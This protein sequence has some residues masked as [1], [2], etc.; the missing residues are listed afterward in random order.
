VLFLGKDG[1]VV[2]EAVL[3]QESG[4]TVRSESAKA[5]FVLVSSMTYPAA[6]MSVSEVSIIR[7]PKS[8]EVK[9]HTEEGVLQAQQR[10]SL[11]S[12]HFV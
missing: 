1:I 8:P 3:L 2:F 5:Q 10:I 7:C 6:W 4:V 11:R 12:S 9:A